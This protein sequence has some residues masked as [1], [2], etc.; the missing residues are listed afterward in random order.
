MKPCSSISHFP[1][2]L[3]LLAITAFYRKRDQWFERMTGPQL[4]FWWIEPGHI[5]T[6]AEASARLDE[7]AAKGPT[8][9]AFGWSDLK[10]AELWRTQR[11]A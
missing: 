5:P 10:S 8:E 2:H 9:R 7:L 4:V 11:C 1:F 6:L 3:V